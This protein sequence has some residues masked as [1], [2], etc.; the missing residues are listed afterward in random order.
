[1]ESTADG[2]PYFS[3]Y[4]PLGDR[5]IYVESE[6]GGNCAVVALHSKIWMAITITT[7]AASMELTPVEILQGTAQCD[8][9]KP[10]IESVLSRIELS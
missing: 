9:H 7:D 8:R 6:S 1:L 4:I 5:K 2:S 3:R 10:F